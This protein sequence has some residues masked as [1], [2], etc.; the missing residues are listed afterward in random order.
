MSLRDEWLA[1]PTPLSYTEWLRQR[2][3]PAG[4]LAPPPQP[5][6]APVQAPARRTASYPTGVN[7]NGNPLVHG[8]TRGWKRHQAAGEECA[9]CEAGHE[10]EKARRAADK[11]ALR[12]RN[13]QKEKAA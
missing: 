6:P 2:T 5:E 7:P 12:A 13:R 10:A 11:R 9:E 1:D 4:L 3:V 8:S